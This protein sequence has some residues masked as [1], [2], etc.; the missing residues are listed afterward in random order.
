MALRAAETAYT[1]FTVPLTHHG[2]QTGIL[3][4]GIQL[5]TS[6]GK[7]TEKLYGK[8]TNT[9]HKPLRKFSA[10][11]MCMLR[12]HYMS[13][14]IFFLWTDFIKIGDDSGTGKAKSGD[15]SNK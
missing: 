5:R 6:E 3:T 4:G 10:V 1:E 7:L 12:P 14:N 11:W 2:E 15:H 8:G 13:N 9:H